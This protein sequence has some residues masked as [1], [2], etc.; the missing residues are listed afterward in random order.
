MCVIFS[1]FIRIYVCKAIC[2]AGLQGNRRKEKANRAVYPKCPP[3]IGL[4]AHRKD[5]SKRS[6]FFRKKA[7]R[8]F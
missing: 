4:S 7:I 3:F 1:G 8:A 6:L 2:K 5:G